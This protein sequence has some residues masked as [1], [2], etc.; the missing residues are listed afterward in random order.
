PGPAA[1]RAA[2][3]RRD[4]GSAAMAPPP[5]PTLLDALR[6]RYPEASGRSLKQ[7]L[8]RGRVLVNERPV[9]DGRARLAPGDRVRLAE[10]GVRAPVLPAPLRLIHED[11]DLLVIEKPAGLLTIATEDERE[12]PAYRR[13]WAH[14]AARRPPRRPFVVHRL[15][16]DTSGLLVFATSPAAKRHLQAQFEAR[17]AERRY[18]AVVEGRVAADAGTLQSRLVQDQGLRVRPGRGGQAA[19]THS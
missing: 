2:P 6:A 3:D 17:T 9:R 1:R 19:I 11:D 8:E 13:V 16:R 7:W 18:V 4:G 10:G 15:D 12:R 5:G 14:L